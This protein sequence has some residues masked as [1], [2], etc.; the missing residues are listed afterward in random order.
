MS[1][2]KGHYLKNFD[3]DVAGTSTNRSLPRYTCTAQCAE[4]LCGRGIFG[5]P[6]STRIRSTR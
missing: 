3:T 5:T 6:P 4:T 2:T 1:P